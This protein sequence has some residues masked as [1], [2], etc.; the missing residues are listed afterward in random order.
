MHADPRAGVRPATSA[1]PSDASTPRRAGVE[2]VAGA[3]HDVAGLHVV[4]GGPHVGARVDRH[5]DRARL[6]RRRAARCRS[7]ITTASAPSG[8]GAPVMIRIASPGRSGR[9]AGCAGGHLGRRPAGST[10]RGGRCRRPGTAYPSMAVLANGGTA[11]VATTSPAS[12]SPTAAS[13]G[14][15]PRRQGRAAVE[16]VGERLVERDHVGQGA[17]TMPRRRTTSARKA[18]ELGAEVVAVEGQLDGR[19]QVVEL[20]GRCRS[21]PRRTR[22]RRPAARSAGWRWRR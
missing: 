12:T 16:D 20:A 10:G 8:S 11:S 22:T 3:E 9:S 15:G 17:Q 2:L 5:V 13:A 6:D 18:R 1:T 4:A 7:T 19:L 21:G 14:D